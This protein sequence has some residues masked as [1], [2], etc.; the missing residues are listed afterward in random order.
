MDAELGIWTA[1]DAVLTDVVGNESYLSAADIPASFEVTR[2]F[3]GGP[4]GA[5]TN[6]AVAIATDGEATVS[7]VAPADDGGRAITGY[8][9]NVAHGEQGATLGEVGSTER[10]KSIGVLTPG[11][12]YTVTVSASN[13]CGSTSS[14]PVT[15]A[16]IPESGGTVTTQ[17]EAGPVTTDVIVPAGAGGGSVTITEAD[18]DPAPAG[19]EFVGQQLEIVSTAATTVDNPLTLVFHVD[20]PSLVPATIFRNGVPITSSC[21]PTGTAT[22]SPCIASGAGTAE[23]T[24]LTASASTWNVGQRLG[25]D[26]SGFLGGLSNPPGINQVKAGNMVKMQFS[27]GGDQ[28]LGVIAAGYPAS[29][30][31]AC[32]SAGSADATDPTLAGPKVLTYDAKKGVYTY[33]WSTSPAWKQT[34]RTFVLKLT[35]GT[36]HYA[37]FRFK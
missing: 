25:Y 27:L 5:P 14:D 15:V 29:A 33:W 1:N 24:I 10:T 30:S 8:G 26:F 11:V 35:D 13:A 22:P 16:A 6:V 18:L 17:P 21:S 23:I 37:E 20:D 28:G 12:T 19:Y 2:T 9:I 3:Q 4:P 34:C 36:F 31:H 32:G 7:W